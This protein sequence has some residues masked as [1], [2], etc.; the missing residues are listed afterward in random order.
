MSKQSREDQSGGGNLNGKAPS[1]TL[2]Q[3][4]NFQGKSGQPDNANTKAKQVGR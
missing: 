4:P 2:H 1:G 3:P